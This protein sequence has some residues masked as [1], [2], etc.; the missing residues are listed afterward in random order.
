MISKIFF[1]AVTLVSGFITPTIKI[2]SGNKLS[3][4][5]KGPP[6]LFS[7][8][9]FGTM[10][11][12]I[13]NDFINNL[14]K[15]ATIITVDGLDTIKETT[16]DEV[17][18]ALLVDKIDYLS[19]SSFF[20][21]VLSNDRLNRIV[22]LDPINIPWIS[23]EG[24][25]RSAI[26]LKTPTL[27]IKAEKLYNGSKQLPKIQEPDFLGYYIEETSKDVG[28]IDILDDN[29][30]NIGKTTGI[31]DTLE[32]AIQDYDNWKGISNVN[33]RDLRKK[34]RTTLAKKVLKFL[35]E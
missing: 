30:V 22:L 20:P 33:I 34:Y 16:I 9:L 10:P 6:L 25:T 13:Y 12:F 7:S 19:H 32:G 21:E 23:F 14:K 4:S 11:R 2:E 8:G 35:R 26:D 28:H 5:G 29:W 31:W 1:L 27:I 3:I 18:N 17:C 15:N 24:L